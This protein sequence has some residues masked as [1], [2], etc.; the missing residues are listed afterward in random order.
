MSVQGGNGTGPSGPVLNQTGN[1]SSIAGPN[2]GAWIG[3][4]TV[5]ED[6]ESIVT[7]YEAQDPAE[8]LPEDTHPTVLKGYSAFQKLHAKLMRSTDS[9]WL[10]F[11]LFGTPGGIVMSEHIVSHGTVNID[12]ANPDAEPI[13]DYRALSNPIDLDIM[14]ENIRYMRKYFQTKDFAPW[15]PTETVPGINVEGE[16]L[17]EWIRQVLVPSNFHPVATASKKP[18]ELGGVVDEELRVHGARRLRIVDGSIM[19]LLPGANTQQT[20]YMIAEK[21]CLEYYSTLKYTNLWW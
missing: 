2:L 9:N 13:V 18:R 12:P 15:N 11:P 16:A 3:L 21:V 8:F 10:W 7:R 17:R 6:Y 5:T 20:V 14:V 19:P 4:P 1:I